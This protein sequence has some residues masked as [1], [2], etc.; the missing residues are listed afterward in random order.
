MITCPEDTT[1]G[2]DAPLGTASFTVL[3]PLSVSDNSGAVQDEIVLADS[4]L[5]IGQVL[6]LPPRTLPYSFVYTVRDE[7]PLTNS[8]TFQLTVNGRYLKPFSW[9]L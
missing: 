9:K 6:T 3:A 8:C 7:V 5:S 2:T 4:T 1:I